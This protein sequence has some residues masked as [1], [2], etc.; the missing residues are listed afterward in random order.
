MAEIRGKMKRKRQRELT[1]P[2]RQVRILV[3]NCKGDDDRLRYSEA[4]RVCML[5]R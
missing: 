2:Y 4:A 1:L 5:P 3:A